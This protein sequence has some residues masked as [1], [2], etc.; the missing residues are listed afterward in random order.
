MTY[1]FI[2]DDE[3]D[4]L[5]GVAVRE[6]VTL[7]VHSKERYDAIQGPCN[8]VLTTDGVNITN[9][10]DAYRSLRGMFYVW[11]HFSGNPTDTVLFIDSSK[12]K[13]IN[14]DYL[15]GVIDG[16]AKVLQLTD[17]TILYKN[18]CNA[19]SKRDIDTFIEVLKNDS[20]VDYANGLNWE[21][22][23]NVFAIPWEKFHTLCTDLFINLFNWCKYQNIIENKHFIDRVNAAED[24]YKYDWDNTQYCIPFNLGQAY[25]SFWVYKNISSIP[26]KV[27][28][29]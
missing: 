4:S 5:D 28:F 13:T 11:K 18:Y 16:G 17:N 2:N 10:G 24:D 25:F 21:Y 29:I 8:K 1:V 14:I 19:C 9:F 20:F 6:D 27:I 22:D 26:G 15:K 3:H 23:I 12:L 7:L